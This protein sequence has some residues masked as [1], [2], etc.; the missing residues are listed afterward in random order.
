MLLHVPF[1]LL[2]FPWK[3]L[4]RL[5]HSINSS[6]C[7]GKSIIKCCVCKQEGDE[8]ISAYYRPTGAPSVRIAR[9]AVRCSFKWGTVKG[10][11]HPKL[12]FKLSTD[13]SY[14]GH[15]MVSNVSL[16]R[17]LVSN[18]SLWRLL[19]RS[20]CWSRW[21][22]SPFAAV[23]RRPQSSFWLFFIFLNT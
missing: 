9:K 7:H 15:L 21:I 5:H 11:V 4:P 20:L 10:S 13:W 22:L 19:V 1:F 12:R 14:T 23:L 2:L 16:G 18:V 6:S 17:L 8:E 3:P